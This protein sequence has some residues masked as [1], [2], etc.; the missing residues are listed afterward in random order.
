MTRPRAS[1]TPDGARA[2][3]RDSLDFRDWIY[4]PAL[5]PLPEY[6]LTDARSIRLLDQGEE[7]ACTGFGLAAVINHL[8]RARG[9]PARERVS[10]RML[11]EMAKRHDRWPGRRYDGS[12]ARGAMKGKTRR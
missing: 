2:A 6:V 12:T 10:A 5:V 3:P 9:G 7:G 4:Q 8:I 1:R 11:Y